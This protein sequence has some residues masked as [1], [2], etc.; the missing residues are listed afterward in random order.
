MDE[1]QKVLVKAGRKDLARSYYKK[2]VGAYPAQV[3]KD[4]KSKLLPKFF[5]D[6]SK[7]FGVKISLKD[8]K[9]Y[10]FWKQNADN[11]LDGLGAKISLMQED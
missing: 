2:V 5:K 7:H 1:I 4:L 8:V 3:A 10:P 9:D 11:L 6:V